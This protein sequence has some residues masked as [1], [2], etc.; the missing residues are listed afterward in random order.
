[1]LSANHLGQQERDAWKG[2]ASKWAGET[3]SGSIG[4]L[5]QEK[6]KRNGIIT[7]EQWQDR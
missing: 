5:D 4:C 1:M 6:K 2:L 3:N 7:Q